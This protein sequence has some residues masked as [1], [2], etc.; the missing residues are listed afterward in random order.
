MY[1]SSLS[2]SL[3]NLSS[4]VCLSG[5]STNL[6]HNLLSSAYP[7]DLFDKNALDILLYR[8]ILDVCFI[9]ILP[10]K[11]GYHH[12]FFVYQYV[13]YCNC[14]HVLNFILSAR[15]LSK[16]FFVF[17]P[18]N[19]LIVSNTKYIYLIIVFFFLLSASLF[20]LPKICNVLIPTLILVCQ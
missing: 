3:C 15:K 7:F 4:F 1:S 17:S 6:L 11:W 9:H 2:F 16:L 13:T 10:I 19:G 5:I 18:L 8:P 20:S 14:L 12:L